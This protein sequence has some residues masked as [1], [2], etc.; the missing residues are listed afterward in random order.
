[1][2][3][4]DDFDDLNR[5]VRQMHWPIARYRLAWTVTEPIHFP[6][7]AGSTLRGAFGRALRK[8]AC[9]T[10]LATCKGCPLYRSCPYTGIFETPAP[11]EH[12]LQKFSQI[13]NPYVIEAPDWGEK[14]YQ[15]GECLSFELVLFG[16]A[17]Y[18]LALI[19]FAFKRAFNHQVGHGKAQFDGLY[20][21]DVNGQLTLIYSETD[22]EII[23]HEQEVCLE[24]LAPLAGDVQM[25]LLTPLRLQANGVGLSPVR[26]QADTVLMTLVRRISLLNEF[27]AAN[28]LHFPFSDMKAYTQNVQI[29]KDLQWQD[30]IRYSSRQHQR[31]HLG[32]VV[33]KID[34]MDLDPLFGSLLQIGQWVHLGKNATFGLGKYQLL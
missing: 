9:M 13:P 6:P 23:E 34:F 19:V 4:V 22:S 31:M 27:H 26:I 28:K 25:N 18:H 10:H 3:Q 14:T 16:R 12:Q 7:Y 29:H 11:A 24:H 2:S 17:L 30:W 1:M 32:G 33:G 8:T 21:L 15:V 20:H 5:Q